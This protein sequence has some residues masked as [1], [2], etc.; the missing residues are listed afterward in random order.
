DTVCL[1]DRDS[2]LI[3]CGSGQGPELPGLGRPPGRLRNSCARAGGPKTRTSNNR[4]LASLAT[5]PTRRIREPPCT[6]VNQTDLYRG[7]TSPHDHGPLRGY[8]APWLWR[9][10]FIASC[11]HGFTAMVSGCT[12]LFHCGLTGVCGV[13]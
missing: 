2:G 11:L 7:I 4:S 1:V 5:T 8:V 13:G 6:P 10:D 9:H 12:N 3:E